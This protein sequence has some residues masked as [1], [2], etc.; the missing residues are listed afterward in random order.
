MAFAIPLFS[1]MAGALF[2]L[3]F[4]IAG[5][6]LNHI[7]WLYDVQIWGHTLG[8]WMMDIQS[9]FDKWSIIFGLLKPWIIQVFTTFLLYLFV[10]QPFFILLPAIVSLC[11]SSWKYHQH[12]CMYLCHVHCITEFVYLCHCQILW[13]VIKDPNFVSVITVSLLSVHPSVC[14]THCVLVCL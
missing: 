1:L 5:S 2:H 13:D 3:S 7:H 8:R 12:Y 11:N 14:E 6:S 10:Q 4:L 9:S